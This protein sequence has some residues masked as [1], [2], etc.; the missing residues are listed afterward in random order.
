M[1]YARTGGWD[2]SLTLD[3]DADLMM[4]ALLEG[5]ALRVAT[6][7]HAY[8]RD[9]GTAR[10]SVA[11]DAF[12]ADRIQ[13]PIRVAEKMSMLL[14]ARGRLAEYAVARRELPAN[15]DGRISAWSRRDR[16]GMPAPRRGAGGQATPVSRTLVGSA[17]ARILGLERKERLAQAIASWGV[18]PRWRRDLLRRGAQSSAPRDKGS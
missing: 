13:S 14:A 7:G 1:S 6:R 2:E 12:T 18:G 10:V 5:T 15:G 17:L 3:D 16:P 8:Y 11:N 4:R 9:H